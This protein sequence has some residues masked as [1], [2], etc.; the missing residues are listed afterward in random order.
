MSGALKNVG[1]IGC[2]T[3]RRHWSATSSSSSS[4]SFFFFLCNTTNCLLVSQPAAEMA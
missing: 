1:M 4:L 2:R 3:K